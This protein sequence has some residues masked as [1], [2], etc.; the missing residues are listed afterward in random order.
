MFC[1]L[2][3]W[4]DARLFNVGDRIFQVADERLEFVSVLDAVGDD[5]PI[6][7]ERKKT[8]GQDQQIVF[9]HLNFLGWQ[10]VYQK[11]NGM[12]HGTTLA[13]AHRFSEPPCG[14][15]ECAPCRRRARQHGIQGVRPARQC[16]GRMGRGASRAPH[17]R[18]AGPPHV[19][20][21]LRTTYASGRWTENVSD[22]RLVTKNYGAL[23]RKSIP[24]CPYASSVIW[25]ET[26][27]NRGLW[28]RLLFNR[29][30]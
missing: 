26:T 2:G 4:A 9:V 11:E 30:T 3:L 18:H 28:M 25:L 16:G 29:Q 23:F 7:I 21:P 12:R 5:L 24:A 15:S 27:R 10:T 17:V 6:C 13:Y 20:F 8:F 14:G 19:A 1:S 22:P